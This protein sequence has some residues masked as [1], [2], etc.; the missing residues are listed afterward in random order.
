[1]NN[2]ISR[3]NGSR[4]R[5]IYLLS[6]TKYSLSDDN[7]RKTTHCERQARAR[8]SNAWDAW[9]ALDRVVRTCLKPVSRESNGSRE[10]YFPL[11]CHRSELI[12][13]NRY[14]VLFTNT[15]DRIN[16]HERIKIAKNNMSNF[17]KYF[18]R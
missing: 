5:T 18:Y 8:W 11:E 2:T 9:N 4:T 14:N 7:V 3:E 1:M 15:L 10:A 13:I 17:C 12:S 16:K 6:S